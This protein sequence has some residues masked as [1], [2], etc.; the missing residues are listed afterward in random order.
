MSFARPVRAL[1][2]L[3]SPA[4]V[5]PGGLILPEQFV[6]NPD[7]HFGDLVVLTRQEYDALVRAA[8][9]ATPEILSSDLP[10]IVAERVANGVNIITALRE[11]HGLSR[12]GLGK[13][14]HVHRGQIAKVEEGEAKL[15]KESLDRLAK[16]LKVPARHF[17]HLIAPGYF[18][19]YADQQEEA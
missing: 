15:R 11:Y 3:V 17:K 1:T 10:P 9:T 14:A 6:D 2:P 5:S 19:A 18:V 12:D 7:G 8:G 4:L 16:A 13:V